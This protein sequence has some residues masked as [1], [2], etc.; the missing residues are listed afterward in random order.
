LTA[1]NSL[2]EGSRT[3]EH[4]ALLPSVDFGTPFEAGPDAPSA[5]RQELSRTTRSASRWWL[6]CLSL[7][8]VLLGAASLVAALGAHSANITSLPISWTVAFGCCV[9]VLFA[10]RGLY[11]THLRAR[12]LDDLRQVVLG[13]ALAAVLIV[14]A[15]G[16]VVDGSG[17]ADVVRLFV[18][19]VV[20]VGAGRVALSRWQARIRRDGDDLRT[21]LV[22]GRGRSARVTA[23]RLLATPELGLEPVGFVADGVERVNGPLPVLGRTSELE[24]VI[25][26]RRVERVLIPSSPLSERGLVE[27]VDRCQEA[28]VSVGLIPQLAQK[29]SRRLSVEHIGDLP[30]VFLDPVDPQGWRFRIKYGFDRILGAL[31]LCAAL[32]IFIAAAVAVWR[33]LGR[34]IF[35]KQL[36]VG[37]DGREFPLLKF[38]SMRNAAEDEPLGVLLDDDIAPGG[39]EGSDRR[40]RLGSFLRRTSLDELPQLLNVVRGEMSLVGPRPER[41]EFVAHFRHTVHRYDKRLRVKSGIT[42]WAQINGLRGKTSVSERVQWDNRYIENWSLWLDFKILLS[43]FPSL[44]SSFNHVE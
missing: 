31:F 14:A 18:F 43:T 28:G 32:P 12:P 19:T 24:L 21:T 15:R 11:R 3:T 16:L 29:T 5:S 40:T 6:W 39:V 9:L 26:E 27:I 10:V 23:E 33:S 35:Y 44:C 17:L 42:G 7:D 13:V 34:P 38:R 30:F 4:V 41:P 2:D 36:R 22:L 25:H 37:L 8:T 20:Y 1:A